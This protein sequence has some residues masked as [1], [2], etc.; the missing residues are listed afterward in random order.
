MAEGGYVKLWRGWRD[1]PALDTP[2]RR[3]AWIWMLEMACWK[4]KRF[5]IKGKTVELERGQFC[6]SREQ[7]AEAWGWSPSGV[8]RFLSRLKTEQMIGRE[9]GQGKS[10]ITICNYSKYQ[11]IP[12]QPGQ[13]FGPKTGQT[14]DR[15]R[16]AKEERKKVKKE[17]D[18][19]P[20]GSCASGDALFTISDFVEGWNE[21][22]DRC[23]LPHI[24]KVTDR[25]KRAF[26]VRQREYPDIADWRKAFRCLAETPWLHGDNRNGWRADPDFFLQAKSFTKLVEGSYG[27][28]N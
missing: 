28:T 7:M 14:S 26:A 10:I 18:I 1:N 12:E 22:A 11:D 13:E 16:T 2:E 5:N 23:G 21:V 20:N 4:A 8:E 15:H 19:E 17:E 9:T 27:K 6:A 25:R 24:D 3:D